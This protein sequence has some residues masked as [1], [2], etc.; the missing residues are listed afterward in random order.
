MHAGE[1]WGGLWGL[2]CAMGTQDTDVSCSAAGNR[3][4]RKVCIAEMGSAD[5]VEKVCGQEKF[6]AT[7]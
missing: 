3:S 1:V 6:N 2:G 7:R 5:K 4:G